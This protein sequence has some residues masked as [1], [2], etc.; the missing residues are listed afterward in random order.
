[1]DSLEGVSV[2]LILLNGCI[3]VV[4]NWTNEFLRK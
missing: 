4:E 1:M 2:L 3:T